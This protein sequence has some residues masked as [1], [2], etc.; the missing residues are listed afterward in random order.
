MYAK[1]SQDENLDVYR[2]QKV[3]QC[4]AD[5]EF[6]STTGYEP[7]QIELFLYLNKQMVND[8][9]KDRSVSYDYLQNNDNSSDAG[10][11]QKSDSNLSELNHVELLKESILVRDTQADITR[12]ETGETTRMETQPV[13]EDKHEVEAMNKSATKSRHTTTSS[14]EEDEELADTVQNFNRSTVV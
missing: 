2:V 8:L 6:F 3:C 1:N 5:D 7:E 11:S 9:R 12:I 14:E 4:V 13:E 10:E